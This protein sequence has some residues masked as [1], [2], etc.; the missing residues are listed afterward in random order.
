MSISSDEDKIVNAI[1]MSDFKWRT[2]DGI[3]NDTKIPLNRFHEIYEKS[4][5]IVRARNRNDKGQPLYS[6]RKKIDSES[7]MIEKFG[8]RILNRISME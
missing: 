7:S 3:L 8:A 4:N 1:E 2:I 5:K 6:T